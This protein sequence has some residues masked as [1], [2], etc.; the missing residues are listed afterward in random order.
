MTPHVAIDLLT[1][2]Q[3]ARPAR[4]LLQMVFLLSV[5][6][7]ATEIHLEPQQDAFRMTYKVGGTYYD[8]VPPPL[9]LAPDLGQNSA[10]DERLAQILGELTVQFRQGK[11]PD[12]ETVARQ[13]PDLAAELRE[14]WPAVVLAE[15]LAKPDAP[16]TIHQPGL[17]PAGEE[18]LA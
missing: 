9:F 6:D 8:M 2:E 14:L 18:P 12:V 13:H 11:Q 17:P 16:S 5:K 15:E 10:S 4:K 7:R 3:D 1:L